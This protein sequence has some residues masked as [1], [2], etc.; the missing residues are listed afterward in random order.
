ME[1]VHRG[2]SGIIKWAEQGDMRDGCPTVGTKGKA[3]PV[4]LNYEAP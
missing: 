2:G 3:P 4:G 1:E